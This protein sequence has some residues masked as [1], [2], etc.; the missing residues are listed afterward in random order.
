V[1]GSTKNHNG[2]TLAELNVV[3]LV[4]SLVIIM[5]L[6]IFTNYFVLITR[7]NLFVE[8]T[9]DS[10][11]LLRSMI[12]ELRYGAG[13][14]QN[15]TITDPNAPVGGWNTSNA[16]FVIIIAVP[17]KN[18]QGN[19][20]IDTD[21]AAPY[22]NEFV[23]YKNGSTLYKRTLANPEAAGNSLKTSCPANAITPSCPADTQLIEHIEN[24]IFN[25]YDQDNIAT[26]DALL[27]RSVNIYVSLVQTMF[28]EDI[29][30]DND[31]RITL[32]NTL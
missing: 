7:S 21:T 28:G 25:L 27:A 8:M 13:V 4:S 15:N 22:K 5:I 1:S 26:N 12:E 9:A 29:R 2:F 30:A 14:R 16:N 20:V 32:R 24:V 23:Y 18:A 6:T 17:A 19:F 10:Q 31:M 11:N 3:L